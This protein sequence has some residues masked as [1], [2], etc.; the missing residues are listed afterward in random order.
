METCKLTINY[1]AIVEAIIS[2]LRLSYQDSL[3]IFKNFE[4]HWK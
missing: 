4:F 3:L 2:V 1:L